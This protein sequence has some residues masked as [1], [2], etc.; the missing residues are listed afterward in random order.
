MLALINLSKLAAQKRAMAL[1][2]AGEWSLWNGKH[3]AC[4]K[5]EA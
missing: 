2:N 3:D 5:K 1:E 4:K